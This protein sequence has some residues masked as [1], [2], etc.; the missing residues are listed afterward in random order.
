MKELPQLRLWQWI[1]VMLALVFVLDWFVQRPDGRTRELNAAIARVG[2]EHLK[3]YPY[4]FHVLRVEGETA[5][6]GTPRSFEVPVTKFIKAI[7]P[8]VN[9]MNANDPAF[10]DAQHDLAAAQSEARAIVLDQPG[11]KAV[12]W[13]IDRRWLTAHGIDVPQP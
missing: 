6:M 11:I 1:A 10:I 2:S 12:S 9:V 3:N 7:L 8:D 4:P 13:E 5:V